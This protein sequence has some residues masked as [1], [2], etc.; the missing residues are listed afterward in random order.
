MQPSAGLPVCF[1]FSFLLRKSTRQRQSHFF[2]ASVIE[3]QPRTEEEANRSG[4]KRNRK[5]AGYLR[6]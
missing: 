3:V 2:I 6:N 4:K 5:N 1:L